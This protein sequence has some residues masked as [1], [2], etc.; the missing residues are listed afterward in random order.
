MKHVGSEIEVRPT[1]SDLSD[2]RSLGV[3]AFGSSVR[4]TGGEAHPSILKYFILKYDVSM[5]MY[6]YFRTKW[7]TG[8]VQGFIEDIGNVIHM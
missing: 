6:S 8:M 4:G 2:E 3:P 5:L 1:V 7:N